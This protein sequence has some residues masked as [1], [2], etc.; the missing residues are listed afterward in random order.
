MSI[1]PA[2]PKMTKAILRFNAWATYPMRGGPISMPT[3]LYVAM[4]EMVTPGEYF[5][6]EPASR[7]VMGII[8]AVPKPTRQKPII[9]GQK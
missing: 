4:M 3:M 1:S 5:L 9:A 8:A 6:E 7:K 2:K